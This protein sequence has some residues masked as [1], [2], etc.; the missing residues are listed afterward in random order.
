MATTIRGFAFVGADSECAYFVRNGFAY[1]C[2]VYD[3]AGL[4]ISRAHWNPLPVADFSC[5]YSVA[6]C[7]YGADHARAEV[8]LDSHFQE[9][10]EPLQWLLFPHQLEAW[11]LPEFQEC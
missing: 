9:L 1:Y 4:P 3:D 11:T 10:C 2:R 6:H 7:E 8:F 5:S